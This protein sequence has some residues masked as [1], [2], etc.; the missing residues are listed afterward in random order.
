MEGGGMNASI[1]NGSESEKVKPSLFPHSFTQ[2]GYVLHKS[3]AG[4]QSLKRLRAV[5]AF[6]LQVASTPLPS[7]VNRALLLLLQLRTSTDHTSSQIGYDTD[8]TGKNQVG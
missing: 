3:L 4:L 1:Q 8:E 6:G 5:S 7:V 2:G